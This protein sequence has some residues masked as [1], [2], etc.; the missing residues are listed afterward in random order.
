[1][2]FSRP[3]FLTVVLG[4]ILVLAGLLGA[5][6]IIVARYH[7]NTAEGVLR[8]YAGYAADEYARRAEQRLAYQVYPALSA[9]AHVS[10]KGPVPSPE[11]LAV[12]ADSQ[13][14]KALGFAQFAFRVALPDSGMRCK[15]SGA[16]VLYRAKLVAPAGQADPGG[17]FQSSLRRRARLDRRYPHRAQRGGLHA[18]LVSRDCLG[19]AGGTKTGAGLPGRVG[20]GRKHYCRIR[21][22]S[23]EARGSLA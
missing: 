19:R 6:A 18:G 14:Q 1:M 16:P 3:A 23:P 9:L 7:R 2:R 15:G 12:H 13:T 22:G 20:A 17:F 4:L 8:D 10:A 11:Q 21:H 5:Q